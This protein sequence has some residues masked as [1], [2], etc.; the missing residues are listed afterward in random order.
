MTVHYETLQQAAL[1]PEAFGVE[2]PAALGERHLWPRMPGWFVRSSP[3]AAD[4]PEPS[5]PTRTLVAA[6]WGLVPHWVKSASDGRLRAP[7]LVNAK[8]ETAATATAFRD[9]WLQGQRCI[10][11]M[12]AFFADDWR[13]GKAVATRIARVDGKPMGV[14]GL[15]AQW[16]G[17]E[18]EVL[19]S[20]TLLTVAASNHALMQR[21]QSPGSEKRM[22][23][24]LGEGAYD[25]WLN[26]RPEKASEF[27]R[28]YAP[29]WLTANPVETKA[30]K[31]P[32]GWLG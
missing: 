10:V 24:V 26:A 15:W 32:K 27:M 30:D 19:L 3:A 2:P 9:A 5:A 20:Y 11:P 13:S 25:A 29:Q 16:T 12:A 18:G 23:V 31:V 7:K 4:A 21:Y 17:P 6:Q 28:Q 8:A 22:P 1:Y 14:A